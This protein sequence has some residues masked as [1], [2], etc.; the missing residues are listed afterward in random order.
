MLP[1]RAEHRRLSQ[2]VHFKNCLGQAGTSKT[3]AYTSQPL[4]EGPGETNCPPRKYFR[5]NELRRPLPEVPNGKTE[6]E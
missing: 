1:E 4:Q 5:K 6:E 3:F 2:T